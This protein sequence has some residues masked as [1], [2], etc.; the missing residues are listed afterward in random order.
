MRKG[1]SYTLATDD[2]QLVTFTI[3]DLSSNEVRCQFNGSGVI[4]IA[5]IDRD[6]FAREIQNGEYVLVVTGNEQEH[7]S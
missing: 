3:L 7:P 4:G 1:D 2:S 5:S 6:R